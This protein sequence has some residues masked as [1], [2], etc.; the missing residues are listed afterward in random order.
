MAE[1]S[2]VPFSALPT[3]DDGYTLLNDNGIVHRSSKK[4]SE[5]VGDKTNSFLTKE[6]GDTLYQEKG[7]YL[8][9]DDISGKLDK[10]QYAVDSATFLTEH[11]DIS[12][13]LDTTAFSTVSGEFLTEHQP[14]SA[15]EW[16][17]VYETVVA[18]SGT[19]ETETV[20]TEDINEASNNAYN[21]A[22]EWVKNQNYLTEHQDISN[23]LDTTAFSTVSGSFL[24]AHQ[25]IS[26][27]MDKSESANFYPMTGNPSGFLTKQSLDDYATITYVDTEIGKIGS[28]EVVGLNDK[29]PNVNEPSTKIIYLTKEID[30]EKSDPYTEW[31]YNDTTSAWECIGE[32]TL[33]LVNYY[34]KNETS[35]AAEIS[36]ALDLKEDKI[37]VAVYN[38]NEKT[39][40]ADIKAAYDAGN[41]IYLK[42]DNFNENSPGVGWSPYKYIVPL[43]NFYT[44]PGG[45]A[46]TGVDYTPTYWFQFDFLN[47]GN[48][49]KLIIVK[50]NDNDSWST[51]VM[52]LNPDLTDYY[53]KSETSGAA[54]ISAALAS[55]SWK[56]ISEQFGSKNTYEDSDSDKLSVYIGQNNSAN[57]PD[58]Y[59]L[60]R[61]N[62]TEQG[63]NVGY[64]NIID[65]NYQETEPGDF[66]FGKY[67]VISGSTGGVN[68]GQ[69]NSAHSWGV[70]LGESNIGFNDGYNFGSANSANQDSINIGKNNIGFNGGYNF[71][72]SNS[73]NQGSIN[74]GEKNS[75]TI[76]SYNIGRYNNTINGY[77]FGYNNSA[78]MGFSIGNYNSAN[79]V[80][81]AFGDN[82][83]ASKASYSIGQRNNAISGSFI[84]GDTNKATSGGLIFGRNN[85]SFDG[86]IA[87]GASNNAN[88]GSFILGNINTA[89]KGTTIIGDNNIATYT[90]IIGNRNK[91]NPNILNNSTL[92]NETYIKDT[93]TNEIVQIKNFVAGL[94]NSADYAKNAY[95]LGNKNEIISDSAD[96]INGNN[97]GYT[98][99]YGWHNSANRNY[100]M[101]IGYKA[102]ASGGE[103]IAIGTPQ[104]INSTST[105]TL[106]T[107]AIGYK[108]LAI[109]SDISGIGNIAIDSYVSN[110]YSGHPLYRNCGNFYRNTTLNLTCPN[111]F[112]NNIF[113]NV[114]NNI[115]GL[116]AYQITNNLF[117]D[118]NDGNGITASV[119]YHNRIKNI[120]NTIL[121]ATLDLSEN[122]IVDFTNSNLSF[123][124]RIS[125]NTFN[126]NGNLSI[127]GIEC[128]NNTVTLTE[129]TANINSF[130]N[131]FV[132]N[133]TLVGKIKS[134][135]LMDNFIFGSELHL[136]NSNSGIFKN[137][138]GIWKS[139]SLG[140]TIYGNSYNSVS[141][142]GDDNRPSYDYECSHVEDVNK[143]FNWGNN[144]IINVSETEV[145]GNHNTATNTDNCYI[146]GQGNSLHCSVQ[147]GYYSQQYCMHH[148]EVNGSCNIISNIS[149]NGASVD[150]NKIIGDGNAIIVNFDTTNN[151]YYATRN[152]LIGDLNQLLS[153][154]S[155]NIDEIV[156]GRTSLQNIVYDRATIVPTTLREWASYE[157]N[158]ISELSSFA[159]HDSDRNTILGSKNVISNNINDSIILGHGN[160]IYN[161]LNYSVNTDII[162]GQCNLAVNGSNDFIAGDNIVASGH[163]TTAIGDTLISN[164][165]QIIIGKFNAPVDAAVRDGI[166][167]N[168]TTSAVEPLTQ[169]GVI[170]AIGNGT[171]NVTTAVT[172]K[173]SDGSPNTAYVDSS[174]NNI[175][176]KPLVSEE[177]ITR[178]NAMVVSADGTVSATRFATSGIADLEAKIKELENI[179]ETYSAKWVLTNN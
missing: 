39:S 99:I 29:K 19:W 44:F 67:N 70:N 86:S 136:Q 65:V 147:G 159:T 58:S 97:D 101:A 178:S 85:N 169:S 139:I 34:K 156:N 104:K 103:N 60:G 118:V 125:H 82:N 24:T 31:I 106:E 69:Y 157:Q 72:I 88:N 117:F 26:N 50:I 47:D 45:S 15:D 128:Y 122:D 68:L 41:K 28:F 73:S 94:D 149:G 152:T 62:N 153:I 163:Q 113:Y 116:S 20:W 5:L 52:P 129:G 6:E 55:N 38:N 121:S 143:T 8:V 14:I 53:T 100:D 146:H 158:K 166:A 151:K 124:E 120:N 170:F 84:F 135:G 78:N 43:N 131:N 133:T 12:N 154:P 108:N 176:S 7:D 145:F 27:K 54:E 48:P 51:Q 59:T 76:C 36:A 112:Q 160:G 80:G 11:Q 111:D 179:I 79:D 172:G 93:T 138:P 3:S 91:I 109:R 102:I 90:D 164:A 134:N 130:S 167:W 75:S 142:A 105:A 119:I 98:F 96:Y 30:S 16:N 89:T 35:G 23:K 123:S 173:N 64:Y 42:L 32:T 46:S 165:S 49:H 61:N 127:S 37:F 95:I 2:A 155:A 17:D 177:Y 4:L 57:S 92:S 21:S 33:D 168:E 71:G 150:Y 25:D 10:S 144:F 56:R 171:Y 107:K 22:V 1:L 141:I 87:I 174:G 63:V 18:N 132:Y 74:I 140:S 126:H 66:N 114:F 148:C 83:T 40:F 137:Y 162:L 81:Y 77:T 115:T 175:G 161:D 110:S 9:D 13:K